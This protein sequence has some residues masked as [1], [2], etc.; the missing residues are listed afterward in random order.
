MHATRRQG[1]D[2]ATCPHFKAT[3]SGSRPGRCQRMT[4]TPR[5][6]RQSLVAFE[7]SGRAVP[8]GAVI[9]SIGWLVSESQGPTPGCKGTGPLSRFPPSRFFDAGTFARADFRREPQAFGPE[10][11]RGSSAC[12][13]QDAAASWLEGSKANSSRCHANLDWH[14]VV[15]EVI[16]KDVKHDAA[17]AQH[18]W[19]V[20]SVHVGMHAHWHPYS[21]TKV[22]ACVGGTLERG[23][24][25]VSR[26][27]SMAAT[28]CGH[29]R[30]WGS[31]TEQHPL[32][33][34]SCLRASKVRYRPC[35]PRNRRHLAILFCLFRKC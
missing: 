22:I 23:S 2:A 16:S 3:K 9:R 30:S 11:G 35:R 20:Y 31:D 10:A 4:G 21:H 6:R 18:N 24:T 12:F 13:R 1:C 5:A 7:R 27:Y 15:L 29:S 34:P 26:R 33:T 17:D 32:F 19:E 8:A 25:Q 28:L 14:H